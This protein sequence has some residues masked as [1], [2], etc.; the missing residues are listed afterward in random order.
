MSA[1]SGSSKNTIMCGISRLAPRRTA[2]RAGRRLST[3]PSVAR[4][5]VVL[6]GAQS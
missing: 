2:T 3:V 4:T 1:F 6:P 5:G